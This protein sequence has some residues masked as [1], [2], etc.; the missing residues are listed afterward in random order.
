VTPTTD[1]AV[2]FK[3]V[4]YAILVG[5]LPGVGKDRKDLLARN[6][7]LFPSMGEWLEKYAKQTC[8]VLVVA[9]HANTNCLKCS[10]YAIKIP[11]RNFAALSRLD[12]NRASSELA[13]KLRVPV[14]AVSNVVI[15]GNHSATQVPDA[16]NAVVTVDGTQKK[17][18]VEEKWICDEF[19]PSIQERSKAITDARGSFAVSIANAIKDTIHDWHFGTPEG[20]H[21]SLAVYSDGK[22]YGITKD[23]FFSFPVSCKNGTY[24]IVAG[25]HINESVRSLIK[26]SEEEILEERHEAGLDK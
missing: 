23:I 7:A 13:R 16:T 21:V 1:P 6:G 9:S 12:Q 11:K 24:S 3:D 19:V 17:A 20:E 2:A 25:L 4:D 26:K 5:E 15:W 22:H 10:R 8:K 14:R 18:E